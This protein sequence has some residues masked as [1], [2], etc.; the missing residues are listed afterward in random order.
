MAVAPK[1]TNLENL[2]HSESAS[3]LQQC[4]YLMCKKKIGMLDTGTRNL[5]Y[6]VIVTFTFFTLFHISFSLLTLISI[7]LLVWLR[8]SK[9]FNCKI[10]MSYQYKIN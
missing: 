6:Y 8:L 9:Y 5:F 7:A 3:D 1:T 2:R 10:F 4:L